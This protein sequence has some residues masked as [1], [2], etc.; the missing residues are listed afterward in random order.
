ML[1][2]SPATRAQVPLSARVER[3]LEDPTGLPRA[4]AGP[5]AEAAVPDPAEA[6]PPPIVPTPVVAAVEPPSTARE[7]APSA[8]KPVPTS[9]AGPSRVANGHKPHARERSTPAEPRPMPEPTPEP[10]VAVP[11][12]ADATDLYHSGKRKLQAG[13]YRGAIADLKA[14]QQLRPSPRTLALLGQAY[15]DSNDLVLAEKT[16]QRAGAHDEAQLLLATLYQQTGRHPKARKV[17]EA[18]LAAHPD[19][20]K[21]EWVRNLLE[22]L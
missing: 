18:F 15:F 2:R 13:D 20:P 14:S 1:F 3:L 4:A 6:V 17:Y 9:P 22:T 19:H 16:L 21:A 11:E 12:G 7:P 5:P 10:A 8:P